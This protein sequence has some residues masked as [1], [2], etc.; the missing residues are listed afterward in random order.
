MKFMGRIDRTV[1]EQMHLGVGVS[2]KQVNVAV[3][4]DKSH[5]YETQRETLDAESSLTR[6][7]I[8][9]AIAQR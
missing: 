8:G 7:N 6:A 1:N 9:R 3:I 4:R 2:K 5:A